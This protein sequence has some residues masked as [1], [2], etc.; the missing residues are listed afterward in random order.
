MI[1][2]I[3]AAYL[4]WM[5]LLLKKNNDLLHI[6]TETAFKEFRLTNSDDESAFKSTAIYTQLSEKHRKQ[7]TMILG[8]GCVFMILIII[9]SWRVIISF[10]QE[11]ELNQTQKNFLLSITHELKSPLASVKLTLQTLENRHNIEVDKKSKLIQNA[12]FDVDR[13]QGMVDNLLLSAR[14][15]SAS[16]QADLGPINLSS[17]AGTI[18]SHKKRTS[19][20][21]HYLDAHIEENLH[22]NGDE[23]AVLSVID[24]LLENAVK[25]SNE[26]SQIKLMVHRVNDYVQLQVTDEGIG[27]P[28]NERT[29]I[30]DKFYRVGNEDTRRTKGSGLGLYIVKQIVELHHGKI[31]MVPNQPQGSCFQITFPLIKA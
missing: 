2:Y 16:F 19:A 25:Y 18:V 22:I 20:K 8:K 23:P 6:Q 5:I 11:I 30:F 7:Q 3:I 26:G 21:N 31:A 27:I 13:L 15:E 29:K 4:W 9:L 1:A 17:I 24:N 10:K 14:L 28:S 12:L